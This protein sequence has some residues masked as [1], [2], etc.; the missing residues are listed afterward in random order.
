MRGLATPEA[1]AL[2]LASLPAL[3]DDG[4]TTAVVS[5]G[6][7]VDP[8]CRRSIVLGEEQLGINALAGGLRMPGR[9]L[10]EILDQPSEELEVRAPVVHSVRSSCDHGR[11][12]VIA[13]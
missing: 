6:M 11:K 13:G 12:E 1:V 2:V 4:A 5:T 3:L 7:T 10:D 8:L 9:S